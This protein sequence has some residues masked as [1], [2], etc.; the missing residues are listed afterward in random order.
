MDIK[1][2]GEELLS[3]VFKYEIFTHKKEVGEMLISRL[4]DIKLR[5]R[6]RKRFVSYTVAATVLICITVGSCV[7]SNRQY[8]SMGEVC[9]ITLPDD[10][11]VRLEVNSSLS[12]NRILW[13]F[14]RSVH[15]VG[16][17][18][19]KVTNGKQFIVQTALGDIRVLGTEFWVR[20]SSKKLDV[21]CFEG[22][23]EVIT[24]IG[25]K[26]LHKGDVIACTPTENIFTPRPDY[27]QYRHASVAEV[28]ERIESIYDVIVPQKESYAD[29]VFDGA[30]T[31]Q[32]LTEALD[33]LTLSCDMTYKI[34]NNTIT[35]TPNE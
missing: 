27:Y 20:S 28:L 2:I 33:V 9:A 34:E 13:H 23:V 25:G 7:L 31:T 24:K 30:I 5:Q 1:K 35:I 11:Q 21:E 22:R 32:S 29:V 14:R 17:A 3:I 4:N 12:Y 16:D 26:I 6:R 19:F 10:S 18:R 8:D 15:L